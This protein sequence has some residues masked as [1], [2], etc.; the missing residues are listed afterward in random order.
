MKF[1]PIYP[2]S[3]TENASTP[4][5]S[6]GSASSYSVGDS[7]SPAPSAPSTLGSASIATSKVQK[8]LD[9]LDNEEKDRDDE[10]EEDLLG[11]LPSIPPETLTPPIKFDELDK[12]LN[13]TTVEM[14]DA[15]SAEGALV[16]FNFDLDRDQERIQDQD[17][18]HGREQVQEQE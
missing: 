6:S 9:D 13:Q 11:L 12:Y 17:H 1:I 7:Q 4:N 8:P 16:D 5:W 3:W 2:G 18:N 10:E 14:D 15:E